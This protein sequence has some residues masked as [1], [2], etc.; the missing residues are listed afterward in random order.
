LAA[1]STWAVEII[2][3]PATGA[4][5]N[6]A[7]APARL[8]EIAKV[9]FGEE[10]AELTAAATAILSVTFDYPSTAVPPPTKANVLW[11][12]P[13][14]IPGR[15][16]LTFETSNL[17]AGGQGRGRTALLSVPSDVTKRSGLLQLIPWPTEGGGSPP[18]SFEVTPEDSPV[19][20]R[21]DVT[22]GNSVSLRGRLQPE[23]QGTLKVGQ[24]VARAFQGD[25]LVSNSWPVDGDGGFALLIPAAVAI[26]PVNLSF[27]P[28]NNNTDPAL[29]SKPV[30]LPA[31]NLDVKLPSYISTPPNYFQLPL[32]TTQGERI[33][34]GM[35]V[36]AR[37]VLRDDADGTTVFTQSTLSLE[38]NKADIALLPGT[39]TNPLEYTFVV[40]PGPTSRFSTFCS[41]AA[42]P[43]SAGSTDPQKPTL[44]GPATLS[45]RVL[46]S[47]TVV[48]HTGSAS[49]NDHKG[50]VANVVVTATLLE[51]MN[52]DCPPRVRTVSAVTNLNGDFDLLLDPGNYR[53]DYVPP[54]HVIVPRKTEELPIKTREM[55]EVKLDEAAF[56]S[57]VVYGPGGEALPMATV[58]LYDVGCNKQDNDDCPNRTPPLL[59]AEAQ[60]DAFGNFTAIVSSPESP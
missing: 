9:T 49:D 44:L 13:P 21:V 15:P 59:R 53:F 45:F 10:D 7:T 39:A 28:T 60:S 50:R 26:D 48:T 14:G 27:I 32:T 42:V 46:F 22:V 16:D 30:Q 1:G 57:G 17:E 19:G 24:F 56:V 54:A 34:P 31:T 29:L 20:G 8:T 4:G 25:R 36:T 2:P 52:P 6:P 11:T 5:D 41:P 37:T 58:R 3:G 35:T 12:V 40:D 47:G 55:R 43:I 33:D 18:Y 51:A 23:F 38:G